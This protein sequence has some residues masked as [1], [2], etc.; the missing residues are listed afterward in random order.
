MERNTIED[1]LKFIK[2]K[3]GRKLPEAW[4]HSLKK[5]ELIQELENH[6]D[7]TQY[8]YDFNL[9]LS[10]SRIKKLPSNLFVKGALDLSYCKGL[11]KWPDR[12]EVRDDLNLRESGILELPNKLS[13]WGLL[14]LRETPL[15]KKYT[16]DEI[17]DALNIRNSKILGRIWL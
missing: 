16:E 12:L 4:F 13:V 3:E 1:I 14:D 9:N 10:K 6:P 5:H 2:E 17:Y 15:S 8:R 7:D 11:T